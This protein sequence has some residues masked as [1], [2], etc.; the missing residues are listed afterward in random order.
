MTKQ[1]LPPFTCKPSPNFAELLTQFEGS[2]AL[3]TFQAGKLCILS[4]KDEHFCSSLLRTF[5]NCMGFDILEDELVI[6]SANA[7]CFFKNQP[8]L[9]E[10]YPFGNGK[11]DAIFHEFRRELTGRIDAHDVVLTK[12][13]AYIVYTHGNAV[14]KSKDGVLKEFWKPP[15]IQNNALEDRCHINGL[16]MVNEQPKYVSMLGTQNEKDSW[17]KTL[18]T[19]GAIMDIETNEFVIQDLSMPHSPRMYNNQLLVLESAREC[20]VAIDLETGTKTDIANIPGFLRGMHIVGDYAIIGS[21]KLR[22]NSS[23]FNG[24]PIA[25]K[26]I[27]AGVYIVYIPT[28]AIVGHS[29]YE[30]TVDE[31]FEVKRLPFKKPNVLPYGSKQH[32]AVTIFEQTAY[33]QQLKEKGE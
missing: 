4:A 24:L 23:I 18:P 11:Y 1:P 2:I 14:Y 16:C 9:Q 26:N 27:K 8:S 21:S 19:G 25:N 20:L 5:P 30:N 6:S 3:S 15:F 17:R 10:S 33:W 7:L 13:A 31:I 29:L 32:T 22:K 12:S 28:G